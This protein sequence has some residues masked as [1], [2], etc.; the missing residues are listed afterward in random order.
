MAVMVGAGSVWRQESGVPSVSHMQ[1]CKHWTI[2]HWF[3]RPIIWERTWKWSN[4][5]SDGHSYG[6]QCCKQ[7]FTS[8]V[9]SHALILFLSSIL[10]CSWRRKPWYILINIIISYLFW[11]VSDFGFQVANRL[12]FPFD[13]Y[14]IIFFL[15]CLLNSFLLLFVYILFERQ[16]GEAV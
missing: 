12:F 11:Y 8:H 6:C 14:F 13:G 5:D 7:H 4:Q 16:E 1:E 10:P 2:F 9:M 3:S 15:V